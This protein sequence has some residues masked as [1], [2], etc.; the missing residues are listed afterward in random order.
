ML[1][2]GRYCYFPSI[3]YNPRIKKEETFKTACP[4]TFLS[5][6]SLLFWLRCLPIQPGPWIRLWINGFTTHRLPLVFSN[7]MWPL[8]ERT[9]GKN[10]RDY[11]LTLFL[12]IFKQFSIACCAGD[13]T[14]SPPFK[15]LQCTVSLYLSTEFPTILQGTLK[16]LRSD[17]WVSRRLKWEVSRQDP[18]LQPEHLHFY[19]TMENRLVSYDAQRQKVIQPLKTTFQKNIHWYKNKFMM[20]NAICSVVQIFMYSH[21]YKFLTYSKYGTDLE[22]NVFERQHIPV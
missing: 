9:K 7:G 2:S 16:V 21:T 1:K 15:V 5:W 18:G 10:A 13:V 19:L 14:L 20:L 22:I 6:S 12:S 8:Q 3:S 4:W 11:K 17:A